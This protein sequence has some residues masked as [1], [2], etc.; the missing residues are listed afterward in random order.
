MSLK[1]LFLTQMC[2]GF[3]TGQY[4]LKAQEFFFHVLCIS[5]LLLDMIMEDL[6][7]QSVREYIMY[8]ICN[9]GS[10]HPKLYEQ[11]EVRKISDLTSLVDI[12]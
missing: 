10:V 6:G 1:Y 7:I 3:K 9:K 11:R 2:L 8:I 12:N 5:I 4:N